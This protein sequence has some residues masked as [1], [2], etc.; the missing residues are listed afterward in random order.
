MCVY[1]ALSN[2]LNVSFPRDLEPSTS[3]QVL[4]AKAERKHLTEPPHCCDIN[5]QPMQFN[6]S[7][8]R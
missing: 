4:M 8:S 5:R 7:G 2:A 3:K 1:Y 6:F